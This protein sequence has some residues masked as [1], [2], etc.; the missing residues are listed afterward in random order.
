VRWYR[1]DVWFSQGDTLI[2][3]YPRQTDEGDQIDLVEVME[4]REGEIQHHRIYWGWK[5]CTLIAPVLLQYA[6]D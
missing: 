6:E 2:W 5:G 1:T 4:I 3:E